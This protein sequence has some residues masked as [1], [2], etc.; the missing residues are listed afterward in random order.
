M[1]KNKLKII[2]LITLLVVSLYM[3]LV[4]ADDTT[5]PISEDT[6]TETNVDTTN[7]A[8]TNETNTENEAVETNEDQDTSF[9]IK[10]GDEYLCKDT[11]SIDTPVDGNVFILANNVTIN[12]PIGGDAFICAKNV[13]ITENGY[14]YSNL[15]VCAQDITVKGKVYNIYS[16]SKNLTLDGIVYRDVKSVCDTLNINS[17]IGRDVYV[18]VSNINFK[19]KS[20]SEETDDITTYGNIQGNLTYSSTQ[21]ISI[22][23]GSVVGTTKYNKETVETPS[24]SEKIASYIKSFGALAVSTIV[25][26]LLS[27]WISPKL[28]LK[29]ETPLTIKKVF[30]SIGLGI[31]IPLALIILSILILMIPIASQLTIF[32]LCLLAILF[33]ISV[34]ISII[35]INKFITKKFKVDK[36][37]SQLGTLIIS[38]LVFWVLS[39]IP[40]LGSLVSFIGITYGIGTI[41]NRLI[42]T[43]KKDTKKDNKDTDK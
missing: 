8:N 15:F 24:S 43:N 32:I 36:T 18:S 6:N 16:T 31:L 14:I 13:N 7:E 28:K 9:T 3:P 33:F 5:T 37:I 40:Y 38:T 41:S 23:D 17:A 4:N 22:P 12:S 27:L 30:G 11:V 19:E 42:D 10:N 29:K 1:L 39:L 21:E 35:D 26:W 20:S 34:S 2:S 25:I